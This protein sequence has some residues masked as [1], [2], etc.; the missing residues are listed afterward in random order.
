[1]TA[2]SSLSDDSRMLQLLE[3]LG[4]HLGPIDYSKLRL[5][6]SINHELGCDGDDAA[7]LMAD[8]ADRFSVEF[9]D[10]DA[11]RYFR[12]EGYDL[13]RWRRSQDRR[14]NVALMLG[15]L[16]RAMERRR[17]VTVELEAL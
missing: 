9:L 16:H 17:W 10:Y 7:E 11:Y 2:S 3:L 6:T 1:M 5:D 4:Q 12:P 13:M 8:F 15:M 14:G